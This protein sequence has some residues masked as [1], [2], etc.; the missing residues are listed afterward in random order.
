MAERASYVGIDVAQAWLDVSERPGGAQWRVRHDEEGL[1]E[2]TLRLQR[3]EPE[4]VVLEATGGLE[5]ALVAAL[6]GAGLAVVVVNPRQVR[7]F[8]RATGR[9]AKT[10]ALDAAALAHFAEAVRPEL[11]ALSDAETQALQALIARRRQIVQML[12]AERQRLT[13]AGAAVRSRLRAH[14]AWLQA[15]LDALDAEL[16]E[17]VRR[18]PVWRERDQLLC[19]VPGVGPQLSLHLLAHLPELGQLN[20]HEIAALVGVAPFNRDS[21]ALRGR[22]QVWGGRAR[23]RSALY[24]ATLSATRWNPVIR[25]CYQRLH[26]AGKAKK[27]ALVACMRKLIVILNAMLKHHSRWNE[28][29]STAAAA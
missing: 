8:A 17:Q 15:E 29:H 9:L 18:S 4:R 7:D 12:V 27:L 3:L 16:A 13:R 24:M 5:L 25:D 14:I 20:R 10:D 19:S 23:V 26:N 1:A 22:R 21:G 6:A 11:R 28:H 2:L